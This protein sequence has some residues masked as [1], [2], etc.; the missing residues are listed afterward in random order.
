MRTTVSDGKKGTDLF[1]G[2]LREGVR[3]VDR[4]RVYNGISMVVT[5]NPV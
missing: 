4:F 5:L 3:E 2:D 1:M